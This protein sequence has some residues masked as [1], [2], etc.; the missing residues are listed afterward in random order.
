M[1]VT[2]TLTR[3]PSP[4]G[5]IRARAGVSDDAVRFS[6]LLR[7]WNVTGQPAISLPLH[8]TA[9]G[10]PIGIQ[11]VGAPGRDDLVLSLA[12]QLEAAAV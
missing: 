1:L 11:L 10:V 4:V 6:A 12:A 2:P 3:L 5:S 7:V 9:E 8:A